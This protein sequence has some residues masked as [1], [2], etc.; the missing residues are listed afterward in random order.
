MFT[1][2]KRSDLT[3][4]GSNTTIS[5]PDWA[6]FH[7]VKV[8]TFDSAGAA[9]TAGAGTFTFDIKAAHG[10]AFEAL[11]DG[12]DA[13]SVPAATPYSV[14]IAGGGVSLLVKP[15]G[16]TTATH[17]KVSIQSGDA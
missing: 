10:S 3:A 14:S 13:I 12:T 5:L 7:Q 11:T 15:A 4:V 2:K 8:D 1:E 16:V 6:T 9:V 17:Y